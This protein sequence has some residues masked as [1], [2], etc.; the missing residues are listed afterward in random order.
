MEQNQ[1]GLPVVFERQKLI[2]GVY[3]VSRCFG[4]EFKD[5]SAIPD[6]EFLKEVTFTPNIY[7][8]INKIYQSFYRIQRRVREGVRNL[9]EV[10]GPDYVNLNFIGE[11]GA[12]K[13]FALRVICA[14]LGI[15][16]RIETFSGESGTDKFL[17]VSSIAHGEIQFH[18]TAVPS[19]HR[20]GG[21]IA[22]EEINQM[23]TDRQMALSQ[24][25]VPPFLL[26]VD[27][28]MDTYRNPFTVYVNL[29]NVGTEGSK[30]FNEAYLNRFSTTFVF[31]KDDR[32][33]MIAKLHQKLGYDYSAANVIQEYEFI[34][35]ALNNTDFEV[36]VDLLEQVKNYLNGDMVA[37]SDEAKTISER[38][39]AN[40]LTEIQN[41]IA[42]KN[43]AVLTFVNMLACIDLDLAQEVQEEVIDI[44]PW[45]YRYQKKEHAE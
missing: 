15:P 34:P 44:F 31:E 23:K 32:E 13:S 1:Y 19:A 35:R 17:G 41:G 8:G 28:Y 22:L 40:M 33:T 45:E 38:Q 10:I 2:D 43:A 39:A 4:I 36:A 30:P 20:D 18:W 21:V 25:V 9:E 3:D 29:F 37:R 26:E 16:L 5:R 27:N 6:R 14:V 42:P 7:L 24:A 11:P 12:G